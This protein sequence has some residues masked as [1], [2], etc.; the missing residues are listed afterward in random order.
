MIVRH[1]HHFYDALHATKD[2]SEMRIRANH[3]IQTAK[4]VSVLVQT[5]AQLVDQ[6][7]EEL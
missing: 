1:A 6:A 2:G 5:S 4:L 7:L 3:A